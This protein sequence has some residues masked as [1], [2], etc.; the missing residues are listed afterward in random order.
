MPA[1]NA[2][3]LFTSILTLKQEHGQALFYRQS[4]LMKSLSYPPTKRTS[5]WSGI[6]K[7]LGHRRCY[8]DRP[9]EESG[10]TRP[11]VPN[12]GKSSRQSRHGMFDSYSH[13][14]VVICRLMFSWKKKLLATWKGRLEFLYVYMFDNDVNQPS[15]QHERRHNICAKCF[16]Y[17]IPAFTAA[18]KNSEL[19]RKLRIHDQTNDKWNEA[20]D[21]CNDFQH[22]SPALFHE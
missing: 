3:I 10:L 8:I 2:A 1:L 15:D 6:A 19:V 14:F 22:F 16:V 5:L 11:P 18:A 4:H 12:K 7:W 20:K 17:I 21:K 9:S 13:L